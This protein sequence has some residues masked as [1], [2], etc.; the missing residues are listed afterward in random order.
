MSSTHPIL[1]VEDNPDDRDLTLMAF[2][3]SNLANRIDVARDGQEAL[4]YLADTS[5]PLPAL[6]LLDLK[7][8]RVM[9]LDVL[10]RVREDP[11]TQL[12]PIVVLTS[13]KEE[14]DR[15]RSYISGVNAYVQKPVDFDEFAS[16][17]R[18]LGLFWLVLNEPPPVDRQ[19]A[20]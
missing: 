2:R 15:Y 10:K 20:A 9:G 5:R 14:S 16:A 7:L 6:I 18:E 19:W 3:D 17:V 13:S 4:E 12:V 11:R 1:L 8:P